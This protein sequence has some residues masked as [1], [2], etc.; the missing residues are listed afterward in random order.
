MGGGLPGLKGTGT[1]CTSSATASTSWE[2]CKSRF[3]N[4][5]L[6]VSDHQRQISYGSCCRNDV[7]CRHPEDLAAAFSSPM[8][9]A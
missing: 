4:E 5:T 1:A 3:R 8:I 2:T 6:V 7:A 9:A